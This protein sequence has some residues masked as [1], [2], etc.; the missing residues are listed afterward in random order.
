MQ[1]CVDII[2]HFTFYLSEQQSTSV[3]EVL[4]LVLLSLFS[5]RSSARKTHLVH[6]SCCA[7]QKLPKVRPSLFSLAEVNED[8]EDTDREDLNE[9]CDAAIHLGGTSTKETGPK[10]PHPPREEGDFQPPPMLSWGR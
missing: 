10:S 4:L 5:L 7:S 8:E 9:T 1:R 2:E 3:T 6:C